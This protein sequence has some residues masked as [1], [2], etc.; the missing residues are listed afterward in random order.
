MLK[1]D[2]SSGVHRRMRGESWTSP[3]PK[4]TLTGR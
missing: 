2:E 4:V 3:I 1:G